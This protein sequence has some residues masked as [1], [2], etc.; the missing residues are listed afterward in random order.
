MDFKECF[1][2][3]VLIFWVFGGPSMV[4]GLQNLVIGLLRLFEKCEFDV[5]NVKLLCGIMILIYEN[6]ICGLNG[7][8]SPNV[9]A[10]WV[11]EYMC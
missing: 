5:L 11:I 10:N 9:R 1:I 3:E 7:I 8:H 2:W 6:F 4:D